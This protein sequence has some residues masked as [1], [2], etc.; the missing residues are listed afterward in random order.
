MFELDVRKLIQKVLF[1]ITKF[2]NSS[3]SSELKRKN[4]SLIDYNMTEIPFKGR[5]CTYEGQTRI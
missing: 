2:Q 5:C 3:F 1:G 4:G